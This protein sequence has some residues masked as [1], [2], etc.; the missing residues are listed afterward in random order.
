MYKVVVID[1]EQDV[2]QHISS[3]VNKANVNFEV[4]SEYEN[5]IDA[6][7]GIFADLPDL[8]ITDIK[9][10]YIDGIELARRIKNAQPL[11]KITIMQNRQPTWAL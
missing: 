8:V 9:I 4:I 5:G 11:I 2:R 1:D 3:M 10:P 7:D 6:I